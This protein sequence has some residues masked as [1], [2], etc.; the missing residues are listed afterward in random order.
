MHFM[1]S[2]G[3]FRRRPNERIHFTKHSSG[4]ALDLLQSHSQHKCR[5]SI[6]ALEDP[7]QYLLG[8]KCSATELGFYS[9]QRRVI[10]LRQSLLCTAGSLIVCIAAHRCCVRVLRYF[11]CVPRHNPVTRCCM[12]RSKR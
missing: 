7:P 4:S 12:R 6:V 5:T 2:P 3:G 9:S 1:A 8:T 11:P 10:A